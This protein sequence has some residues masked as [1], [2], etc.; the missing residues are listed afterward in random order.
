[1]SRTKKHKSQVDQGIEWGAKR[2]GD[3]GYHGIPG[4][5]QKKRTARAERLQARLNLISELKGG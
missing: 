2:I 4:H 3:K 5:E 1:M